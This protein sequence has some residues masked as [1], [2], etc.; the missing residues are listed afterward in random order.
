MTPNAWHAPRQESAAE[1]Q[2]EIVDAFGSLDDW[3]DRYHLLIEM[4]RTLP[5]LRPEERTD[6]NRL[7][8]CQAAAWLVAETDADG[9]LHFRAASHSAIVAGLLALLLRVYSGRRPEEIL[10]IRPDFLHRCG[11][12]EH[13]SMQRQTGVFRILEHVRDHARSALSGRPM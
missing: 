6:R 12:D 8:G 4:G 1:A 5:A 13:L 3:T 2:Q 10:E 9:R 7:L 11:L